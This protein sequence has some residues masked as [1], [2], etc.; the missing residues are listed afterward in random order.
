VAAEISQPG[1]APILTNAGRTARPKADVKHTSFLWR[2]FLSWWASS[3][4]QTKLLAVATLV[5]SFDDDGDH[6]L[7]PSTASGMPGQ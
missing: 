5:V 7:P 6:V 4:W 3:A 1:A 2:R